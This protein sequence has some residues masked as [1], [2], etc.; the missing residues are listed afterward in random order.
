MGV[1]AEYAKKNGEWQEIGSAAP[2]PP[3]PPPA[4]IIYGSH[5]GI[6]ANTSTLIS[7]MNSRIVRTYSTGPGPNGPGES[8]TQTTWNQTSASNTPLSH[9]ASHTFK[10]DAA[11]FQLGHANY[12]TIR[13]RYRGILAGAPPTQLV[14]VGVWHEPYDNMVEGG[15][16]QF[17]LNQWRNLQINFK[18]DVVDYVNA[19]RGSNPI[20]MNGCIHGSSWGGDTIGGQLSVYSL[21]DANVRAALDEFSFDSYNS[22]YWTTINTWMNTYLGGKKWGV[23]ETGYT[24]N[25]TPTNAQVLAR[26]QNWVEVIYPSMTIQPSYICWFNS[27]IS[28]GNGITDGENPAAMAYWKALCDDSPDPTPANYFA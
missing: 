15:G 13:N 12:T 25:Q 6:A 1:T 2:P 5:I 21:Y 18:N 22:S 27:G 9:G 17:T 10:P 28:N 24:L 3:P 20:I 16:S 23:W 19:S 7:Q 4:G 11:E 14:W 26:M 8:A